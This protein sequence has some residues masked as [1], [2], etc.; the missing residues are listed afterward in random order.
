MGVQRGIVVLEDYNPKWKELFEEEKKILEE[1]LKEKAVRIEHVGSTAVPGLKSKPII[2]ICVVV[3]NLE[4]AREFEE[5]LKPLDYHFREH[6]GV[7]DR[8][9]YA[10]GPEENRTHYVH[11]ETEDSKSYQNHI[12]F[13]D[14]LRNHPKYIKEYAKIKEELEKEY[15]NIRSE[16]TK[17]KADFISKVIELA[18]K[19]KGETSDKVKK[20]TK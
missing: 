15:K 11:C 20:I 4:D 8:Y 19:E 17:G 13:R 7:D 18:K 2:D 16:Y 3:K 1:V 10:K 12:L 5:L 6:Q 9:F 14:Y